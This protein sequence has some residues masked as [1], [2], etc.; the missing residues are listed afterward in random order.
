ME[1]DID[2]ILKAIA[3]PARRQMLAWLKNPEEH[4]PEQSPGHPVR[5]GVCVGKIVEKTGLSQSTVSAYMDSL[6]RAGLVTSRR[7][8]QWTFYVR[9]EKT[10]ERFAGV[11][12]KEL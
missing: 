9:N 8:G 5:E 10:I 6:Q 12:G 2:E 1:I 4:F 7:C 11:L 3:N